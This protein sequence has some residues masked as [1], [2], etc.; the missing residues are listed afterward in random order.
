MSFTPRN[1]Y[2]PW[3]NSV[4]PP[5]SLVRIRATGLYRN[6]L[7]YVIGASSTPQNECALVAVVPIIRYPTNH[8][9][10]NTSP[11]LKRRKLNTSEASH[12]RQ[13][14]PRPQLFTPHLLES[15]RPTEKA[16]KGSHH[17]SLTTYDEAAENL[18]QFFSGQFPDHQSDSIIYKME[19]D[20]F[21]WAVRRHG[22]SV[23]DI[24]NANEPAT[25]VLQKAMPIHRYKDHFYYL[26][27]RIVPIYRSAAL[28]F[29]HIL[30]PD[31]VLPFV[32]A[33]LAPFFFDPLISQ[34]HWK[35]HDKL[36]DV[37]QQ[38]FHRYPFYRIHTVDVV[39]G[40]VVAHQVQFPGDKE[41]AMECH[42]DGLSVD[43][44]RLPYEYA[45]SNF[46]L[47]LVAGDHVRVIA[48]ENKGRCG[49]VLF[50]EENSADII[51]Y[52]STSQVIQLL[53]LLIS[54]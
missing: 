41:D 42:V 3:Q 14:A 44:N 46:R 32:E 43:P 13:I 17:R 52:D 45:I 12:N 48:G 35:R 51:P 11:P 6:K 33:R 30:E 22:K 36:I 53:L 9:I 38:E 31:E 5:G 18:Q 50:T 47:R 16:S 21:S 34:M 23:A 54:F 25:D 4:I 24:P 19:F 15:R 8:T 26:G 28:S 39:G 10:H 7:G 2:L 37:V 20:G 27:M 29:N 40:T 1:G 49:T